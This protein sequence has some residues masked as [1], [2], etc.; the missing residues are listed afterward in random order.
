[1]FSCYFLIDGIG[2]VAIRKMPGG[3]AAQLSNVKGFSK[4]HLEQRA[5][6][7]GHGHQVQPGVGEPR[8]G[9][10]P[11]QMALRLHGALHPAVITRPEPGCRDVGWSVVSVVRS[12]CL[13]DLRT[14]SVAMHVAEPADVHENVKAKALA[15]LE[16]TWQFV[17]RPAMAQ[18][19]V[20]D[21]TALG[22]TEPL[23]PLL[24]LAVGMMASGIQQGRRQLD[25]QMT[26]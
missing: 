26:L 23:H 25:L 14:T 15:G 17:M 1:M 11:F 7:E 5:L 19:Q 18:A 21:F 20:N 22:A 12:E 8:A 16:S 2:H 24:H 4:V 3:G 9:D 13:L 10:L 6:A